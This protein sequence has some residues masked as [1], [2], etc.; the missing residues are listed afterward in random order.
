MPNDD[1]AVFTSVLQALE[2]VGIL[3]DVVIVGLLQPPVEARGNLACCNG[4]GELHRRFPRVLRDEALS[5]PKQGGGADD[6]CG[7]GAARDDFV[8][9]S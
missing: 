5:G 1:V 4:V 3:S 2:D 7:T 8:D 6:K 9:V